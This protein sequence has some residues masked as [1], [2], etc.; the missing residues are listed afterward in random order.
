M[1]AP[2]VENKRKHKRAVVGLLA[3]LTILDEAGEVIATSDAV[4]VSDV[5]EGGCRMA[6]EGVDPEM[7]EAESP[8]EV[9]VPLGGRQIV[10]RGVIAWTTEV[11]GWGVVAGVR[12][13]DLSKADAAALNLFIAGPEKSNAGISVRRIR[14]RKKRK[15]NAA[16]LLALVFILV[17]LCVSRLPAFIREMNREQEHGPG[18]NPPNTTAERGGPAREEGM[19]D[20]EE[21]LKEEV[22]RRYERG[23]LSDRDLEELRKYRDALHR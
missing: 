22:M 9:I 12:A 5:S 21:E 1:S 2:S 7:L 4:Y 18:H 15:R 13:D 3:E 23:E 19:K 20:L 14:S 11:E 16:V 10:F 8:V 6:V 17:I